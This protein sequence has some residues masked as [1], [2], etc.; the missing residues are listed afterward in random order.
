MVFEFSKKYNY[1]ETINPN[2]FFTYPCLDNFNQMNIFKG[3]S[4]DKDYNKIYKQ[5]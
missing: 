1:K 5:S 3:N 2:H 4:E